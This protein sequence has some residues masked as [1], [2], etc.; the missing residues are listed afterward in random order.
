MKKIESLDEIKK[1]E[2]NILIE[3]DTF[4]MENNLVYF[5]TYGTL[6]GA[7]RH[8]GFIPWDDD[9]DISMPRKDY[10]FF[11]KN[12]KHKYYVV[13]SLKKGEYYYPFAKVSDSR[14]VLLEDVFDKSKMGVYVDIFPLDSIPNQENEIKKIRKKVY[15]YRKRL[16]NKYSSFRKKRNFLKKLLLPFVKL[17]LLPFSSFYFGK[18]INDYAQKYNKETGYSADILWGNKI[19]PYENIKLYP[20]TK[21]KFENR[22]FNAPKDSDYFLSIAYGDYM[23]LPPVNKRISN[24]SFNAY[25]I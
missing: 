8:G 7:V 20:V 19:Y 6:L 9:I 21:I 4:C 23:T 1:I 24:H 25:W 18:K 14:T 22:L 12:F 15:F 11:I 17:A 16:K 3:I 13:N 2:L 10:E 5:L